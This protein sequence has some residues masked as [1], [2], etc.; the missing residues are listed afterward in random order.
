MLGFLDA[1]ILKYLHQFR[2]HDFA[3]PI[4]PAA[5]TFYSGPIWAY[6]LYC[7]LTYY[8]KLEKIAYFEWCGSFY[9]FCCSFILSVLLFDYCSYLLSFSSFPLLEVDWKS[10]PYTV[11]CRLLSWYY[12]CTRKGHGRSRR[13]GRM[14]AWCW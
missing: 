14:S 6:Q 13:S 10:S 5:V 1:R 12:S 11:Q 4:E 2:K 9:E 3:F 7:L 8:N